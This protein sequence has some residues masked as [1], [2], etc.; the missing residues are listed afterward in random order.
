MTES[1]IEFRAALRDE[2]PAIV[3]L[4]A[5]DP[6]GPT[7]ERPRHP[8]PEAY[9]RAF[10]AI[11]RDPNHLLLVGVDR[12]IVVA[13]LQLSFLPNLTRGG[14]WRAQIEGVRVAPAY[15]GAGL[16]EKLI[17]HAVERA[18][19]HNC[20]LVQLTSDKARA[21]ALRFYQRLGFVASHEGMK[22]ALAPIDRHDPPP[23]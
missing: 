12:D 20:V 8:L 7:R 17:E 3:D 13:V 1:K 15:R 4:L 14:G 6:L 19:E 2:L 18:R 9:A 21:D 22:L 23:A 16:G 5:D 10:E 11:D